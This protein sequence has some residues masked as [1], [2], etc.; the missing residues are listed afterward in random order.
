MFSGVCSFGQKP[1]LVQNGLNSYMEIDSMRF[2]DK[3]DRLA[4]SIFCL[5]GK[6]NIAP[7]VVI[8]EISFCVVGLSPIRAADFL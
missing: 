2:I 1:C 3:I 6:A 8:C 4:Y 7:I 5:V